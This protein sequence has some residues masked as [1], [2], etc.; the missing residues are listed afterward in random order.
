MAPADSKGRT[1]DIAMPHSDMPNSKQTKEQDKSKKEAWQPV[2]LQWKDRELA[3]DVSRL[4]VN[5]SKAKADT[6]GGDVEMKDQCG[7]G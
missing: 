3:D 2:L 7:T 4:F 6:G 1:T 5:D